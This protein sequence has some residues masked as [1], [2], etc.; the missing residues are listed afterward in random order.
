MYL[1]P[2]VVVPAPTAV[3]EAGL[4]TSNTLRDPVRIC[5]VSIATRDKDAILLIQQ[6]QIQH[7]DGE[8]GLEMSITERTPLPYTIKIAAGDVNTI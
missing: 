3:G 7:I 2:P 8:A 5:N 4:E 6:Q 1:I